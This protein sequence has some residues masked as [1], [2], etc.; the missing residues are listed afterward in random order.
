MTI[1]TTNETYVKI[2]D[3]VSTIVT[4][5]VY[6]Y[7]TVVTRTSGIYYSTDK[8]F[9]TTFH[10]PP[11]FSYI[12]AD[13]ITTIGARL[14]GNFDPNGNNITSSYFEYGLTKDY[15]NRALERF[16]PE[17]A[18]SI[19][20]ISNLKFGEQYH[21]RLYLKTTRGDVWS[22]DKTFNT[23]PINN[24]VEFNYPFSIG[25]K[26]IYRY[27]LYYTTPTATSPPSEV[28]NGI[29]T[30]EVVS[31]ETINDSIICNI[32]STA[33][34]TVYRRVQIGEPP[35]TTYEEITSSF[36][37]V[38]YQ[39]LIY[40]NWDKAVRYSLFLYGGGAWSLLPIPRYIEYSNVN[41]QLD[42]SLYKNEIGLTNYDMF[43][44]GNSATISETLDLWAYTIP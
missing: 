25:A 29:H 31:V 12:Y 9:S 26:W 14:V 44:G 2:S 17:A 30:W 5:K 39:Y 20:R 10:N 22:E 6:H 24:P 23:I 35:D 41:V 28:R 36:T 37:I 15:G 32:V 43:F 13:D 11:L 38:V 42:H 34:D 8:V 19:A 3:T 18:Q 16:N 33:K 21:F 1:D 40:P 7:R 27:I 4:D